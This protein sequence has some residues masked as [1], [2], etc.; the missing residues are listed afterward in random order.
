ML[1][2]GM[3]FMSLMFVFMSCSED[4]DAI[5]V[6]EEIAEYYDR[7][8]A[9][10]EIRNL[11]I[12]LDSLEI[13]AFIRSIITQTVIGQCQSNDDGSRTIVVDRNFWKESDDL[14]REFLIFHE[15]GHCALNKGHNDAAFP[16]GNCVSIMQSGTGICSDNYNAQTRAEY[17][18][19]FFKI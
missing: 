5:F 9:E 17:L 16:N 3:F 8:E 4:E 7:F 12:N 14:L 13:E 6:D 19:E 10:A 18:D 15:L 11:N 2:C 1:K